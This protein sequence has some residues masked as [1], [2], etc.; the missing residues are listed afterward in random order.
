MDLFLTTVPVH[1][2]NQEAVEVD[3]LALSHHARM[4]ASNRND[5]NIPGRHVLMLIV[6]AKATYPKAVR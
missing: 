3:L 4:V 2:V 5:L 6:V 1:F